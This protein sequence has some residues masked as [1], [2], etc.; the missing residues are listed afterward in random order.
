MP[1]PGL[2]GRR[3]PLDASWGQGPPLSPLE[4][5]A[6][7]GGASADGHGGLLLNKEWAIDDIGQTKSTVAADPRMSPYLHT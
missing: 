4:Y 6:R 1:P 5:E 2:R 3:P 7:E